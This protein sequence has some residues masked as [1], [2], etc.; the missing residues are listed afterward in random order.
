MQAWDCPNPALKLAD[1]QKNLESVRTYTLIGGPSRQPYTCLMV[2]SCGLGHSNHGTKVQTTC[3]VV[4]VCKAESY[5]HKSIN[6]DGSWWGT[7]NGINGTYS[8]KCWNNGGSYPLSRW[9]NHVG[10]FP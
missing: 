6:D 8:F 5:L 1:L 10:S 9:T 3:S 4:V 2:E 7:N